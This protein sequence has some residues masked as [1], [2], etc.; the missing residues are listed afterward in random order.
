MDKK[1][2]RLWRSWEDYMIEWVQRAEFRDALPNLLEGEDEEFTHYIRK[3]A[4]Q[5]Q[6]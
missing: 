2:R 4:G 5:K 3:L 1:G 6:V